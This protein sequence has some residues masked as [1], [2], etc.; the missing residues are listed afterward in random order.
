MRNRL[1][2]AFLL[3]SGAFFFLSP[4]KAFCDD[5]EIEAADLRL[6]PVYERGAEGLNDS[7][8]F[9]HIT[10]YHLYIRK[11]PDIL[12]VLLTETTKDP[13]GI[14][15][16]YAY[17]STE[18]N[19]VN[20]DEIRYLN[21]APLDTDWARF[22]IVDSTTEP[23]AEFG[24]AFHLYIPRVM[25]YGYPWSRRGEVTID[26]GVF[27][28]IRAFG[29]LHADYT[30]GF[31]DNPFMFDFSVTRRT[32]P[33]VPELTDIYSD[34][35][36]AGFSDIAGMGEGK[37]AFSKGADDIVDKITE[38]LESIPRAK[39][40]DVVF[41]IDATGSMRDDIDKLRKEWMPRLIDSMAKYDDMRIALLLYR[42]YEDSWRQQGLPIRMYPF[43]RDVDEFFKNLNGF[44]IRGT[45]GGD[46]PEPVYEALWGAMELY[47]WNAAAEKKVILIG[48]AEPH[49]RPRGSGKYSKE[50]VALTSRQ[51][52]ITIDAIVVPDDKLKRKQ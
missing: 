42:D 19:S 38:S 49:P 10:G 46:I 23:H 4:E 40:V 2:L 8:V 28:N 36:V 45:E 30:N 15:D 32:P 6:V 13:E 27:I 24:E 37:L 1:F 14:E 7:G 50:L 11:K 34:K 31:V 51:K 52:N 25:V 33:A 12:S 47:P 29:S 35:A 39:F 44:T 22:S 18:W 5:L 48:D 9:S 41:C 3:V 26:R 16:N 21:G 43:T 17:R 20:G